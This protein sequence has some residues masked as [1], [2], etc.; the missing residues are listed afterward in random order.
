MRK[1]ERVSCVPAVEAPRSA[2]IPGSEGRYMSVESGPSAVRSARTTVMAS[3]SGFSIV[4]SD[5]GW[6]APP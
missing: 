2:A 5:P 6:E 1:A 3:V 4:G